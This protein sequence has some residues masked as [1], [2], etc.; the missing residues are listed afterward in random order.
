MATITAPRPR[1]LTIGQL[2]SRTGVNLETIRYYERGGVL[3]APPRT[4]GGHR[5][6]G[7]E[8]L[9][10][11]TFIRR[12]RELGFTLNDVRAFLRL[13]DARDG[14]CAEARELGL[15]HLADI[16]KKIADLRTMGRVLHEMVA[17]C[18]DDTLPECPLIE[19]L[20]RE[21]ASTNVDHKPSRG[22]VSD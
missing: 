22:A 19:A 4:E 10:R 2:A 5:M 20:F 11:L 13:A 15:R 18:A 12:S 17:R 16:K 7:D 9:K 21:A 8:H 6:Y 1:A 14:S 3:S